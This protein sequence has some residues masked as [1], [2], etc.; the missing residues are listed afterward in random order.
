ML[1]EFVDYYIFVIFFDGGKF[2]V[3]NISESLFFYFDGVEGFF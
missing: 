1:V 3:L 2:V